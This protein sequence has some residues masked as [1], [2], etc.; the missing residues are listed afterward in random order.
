M[1]DNNGYVGDPDWTGQ[2][3]IRFTKGDWTAFWGI[4]AI[5]KATSAEDI[6]DLSSN[7]LY[8]YKVSTEFTAYHSLAVQRDLDKLTVLVGVSNLFNEEPPAISDAS[9][10]S[11]SGNLGASVLASQYDYIGRRYF[12]NLTKR[13]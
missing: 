1:D 9:G 4:D 10:V 11:P 6:D 2:L 8:R 3:N 13:F 7:G 5:G 12:V